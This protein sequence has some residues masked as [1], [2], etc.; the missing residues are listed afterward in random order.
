VIESQRFTVN[1]N[2]LDAHRNWLYWVMRAQSRAVERGLAC[3]KARDLQR[4][5]TTPVMK[6]GIR[7]GHH[8]IQGGGH[9]A[10]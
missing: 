5:A 1:A 6:Q 7:A 3:R 2:V 8:T 9:A 4:S 10:R